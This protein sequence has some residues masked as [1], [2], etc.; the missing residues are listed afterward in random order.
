M[1]M[2]ARWTVRL[3]YAQYLGHKKGT[4]LQLY[5]TYEPKYQDAQVHMLV[6]MY[7]TFQLFS[8]NHCLVTGEKKHS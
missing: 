3:L 5:E 2:Q 6:N 7:I 1:G 8:S 4:E